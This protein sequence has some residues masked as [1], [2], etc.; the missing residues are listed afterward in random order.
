MLLRI[1]SP[2]RRAAGLVQAD[3]LHQTQ[4]AAQHSELLT[5]T[6]PPAEE[7]FHVDAYQRTAHVQAEAKARW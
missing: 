2:P 4:A 6:Q 5:S 1:K 3:L 7:P